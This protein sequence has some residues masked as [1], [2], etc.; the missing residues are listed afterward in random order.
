MT[1]DK[2]VNAANISNS[3][4]FIEKLDQKFDSDIGDAAVSAHTPLN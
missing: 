1:L 2:I 3:T 4:E